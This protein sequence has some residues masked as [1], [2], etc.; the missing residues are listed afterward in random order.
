MEVVRDRAAVRAA[1][2]RLQ[3][4]VG[5]VATMGALHAGHDSLVRRARQE[6]ASVIASLFV[7]PMQF[8]Q[9]ED[10]E[11]YPRDEPADL[12]R[13]RDLG[14]DVVFAPSVEAVYPPGFSTFVDVGP[15]GQVL[16]GAVRPGHFRG[17]A[18][19]VAILFGLVRPDRA[20]FGQKDGQQ[21]VVVRRLVTDL[22]LGVEIVVCPTVREGDGLAVS[23]RNA[24]LTADERAAAPVLYRALCAAEQAYHA[25][26]RD[27]ERLRELMQATLAAERLARTEYV[28]VADPETLLEL[29]RVDGA[30]LASLAVRFPSTRLID[31]LPLR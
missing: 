20:Y 7:N 21:T 19:V 15:L 22:A 8:G 2:Q 26:E 29:G 5:F 31:C 4:P 1:R 28:S 25:G 24:Y 11:R 13:L 3:A 14:V 18:T 27:A 17:V 23:S 16:E 10:F 12:A 30:A 6:C 9:G